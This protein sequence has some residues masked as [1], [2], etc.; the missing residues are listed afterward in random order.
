MNTATREKVMFP[1]SAY[2]W[3]KG[4]CSKLGQHPIFVSSPVSF[5]RDGNRRFTILTCKQ[6]ECSTFGKPTRYAEMEIGFQDDE[7]ATTLRTKCG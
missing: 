4:A 5:E 3:C 1:V 7:I 2:V 6:P